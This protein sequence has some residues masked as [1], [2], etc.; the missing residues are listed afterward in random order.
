[1]KPK[2]L[3]R[4]AAVLMFFHF[5]GH[6]VGLAGWKDSADPVEHQ[7]IQQMTGHQFPFMG[8]VH[9]LGDFYEGFGYGCSITLLL[10]AVLLWIISGETST[11]IRLVKKMTVVIGIALLVWA[12]DEAIYFFPFA[13]G[14][15][16]IAGLCCFWSAYLQKE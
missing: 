8:A 12:T 5:L 10:I 16:F 11:N 6:S 4:I 1:M 14:L 9:S 3:L 2:L 7:V 13:T 15:S